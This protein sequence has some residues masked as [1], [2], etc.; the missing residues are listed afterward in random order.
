MIDEIEF[1]EIHTQ[2]DG[3]KLNELYKSLKKKNRKVKS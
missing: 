3:I 1:A 2:G